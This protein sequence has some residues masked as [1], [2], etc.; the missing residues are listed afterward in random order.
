MATAEFVKTAESDQ[1][2]INI[3]RNLKTIGAEL[4]TKNLKKCYSLTSI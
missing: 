3:V 4:H 2:H 1:I